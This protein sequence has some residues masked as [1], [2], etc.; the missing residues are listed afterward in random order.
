MLPGLIDSHAHAGH[1]LVKSL[2]SGDGAAWME[3]C[4]VIYTQASSPA[5]WRA[6]ARL[7]ALERLMFG[8]TTG[9][10][11]LGGG[12]SVMR[13]DDPAHGIAHRQGVAEIGIRDIMV[14]GPTRRSI[15]SAYTCSGPS[16]N[17]AITRR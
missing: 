4:R 5:F 9:V 17:A 3:A 2:C 11:L 14:V 13:T 7:A 16:A 8:V 6:E 1:G 12:D 15:S 10:S